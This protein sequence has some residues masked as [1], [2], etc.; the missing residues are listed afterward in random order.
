V[1]SAVTPGQ[2]YI[3]LLS[4]AKPA[5]LNFFKTPASVDLANSGIFTTSSDKKIFL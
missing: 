5:K 2:L 1:E 4:L 3:S